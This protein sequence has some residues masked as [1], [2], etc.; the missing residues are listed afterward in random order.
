[1]SDLALAI[2]TK[3]EWDPERLLAELREAGIAPATEIQVACGRAPKSSPSGLNIHS[4]ENAS[5]FEL[6]AIAIAR[7][8]AE[9]I[10]MLHADALPAPGWFAAMQT[11][12]AGE[13]WEDGY[14]GPV[15][16]GFSPSD[17]RMVGYLTE[18]VQFHR[19][20]SPG[21]REV[22]GSNLVLSRRRTDG[23]S[24]FSKTRLLEEGLM[25]KRVEDAVVLYA[26]SFALQDYCGRRFRHGRSYAAKRTPKLSLLVAI[27]MT[28]ALPFV[29][30][31]RILGHA[32]R[33]P[34]FRMASLRWLPEIFLAETCWSAGEL[35]GYVTGEAGDAS[36]LD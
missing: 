31:A 17:P 5:L 29:R 2:A 9:W 13:S 15:E 1:M 16:P 25:P 34:Q 7:S 12:I 8:K 26:R 10:A 6:W 27:P 11:A 3:G 36:A 21:L 4:S 22:P 24:D 33:H 19:P 30:T 32:W 28:F 35:V 14:W 18:Y 20:L 23:G